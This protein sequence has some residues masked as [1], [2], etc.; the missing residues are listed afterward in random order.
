MLNLFFEKVYAQKVEGAATGLVTCGN[1]GQDACKIDDIFVTLNN[2]SGFIL[3]VIFPAMFIFGIFMIA[4]PLLNQFA[5]GGENPAAMQL[6]KKRAVMLF[7]GSVFTVGA[8]LII[9]A[10]LAGISYTEV[11]QIQNTVNTSTTTSYMIIERAYAQGADYFPNPL[12][13]VTVQ[14][15]VLGVAN[16]FAYIIIVGAIFGV[17]RGVLYL[18]AAQGNTELINKGKKWIF[19]SLL[20]LALILSA[21]FMIS[22]VS[23]TVSSIFS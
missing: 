14:E 18:V 11:D 8:F 17:I 3:K 19:R 23:N 7:W 22:L 6:A 1:R 5:E 4:M 9:K 21:Q 13:N 10:V 20:A 15:I 16:V 2:F 12:K